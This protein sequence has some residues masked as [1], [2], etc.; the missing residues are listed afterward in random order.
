MTL[1]IWSQR[2]AEYLDPLTEIP[3]HID[4]CHWTYRLGELLQPPEDRWWTLVG[5]PED[6]KEGVEL[7]HLLFERGLP[8]LAE[9]SSDSA[10]RDLWLTG[11]G[12]GLT[13]FQRLQYLGVLLREIGPA[14]E[15]SS[16]MRQ[17]TEHSKGKANEDYISNFAARLTE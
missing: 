6:G 12:P 16:I 15:I 8:L 1:G 7:K 14:S 17:L 3:T 13:R 10:L 4:R 9:M 11:Q 2:I 5:E